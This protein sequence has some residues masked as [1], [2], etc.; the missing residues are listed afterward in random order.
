MKFPGDQ[1][2]LQRYDTDRIEDV[3]EL[4]IKPVLIDQSVYLLQSH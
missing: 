1:S 4:I 2:L 3:C